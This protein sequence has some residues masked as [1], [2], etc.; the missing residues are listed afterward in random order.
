LN[1]SLPDEPPASAFFASPSGVCVYVTVA[2]RAIRVEFSEPDA[3]G[4]VA[5]SDRDA[6][7]A[8]GLASAALA[9]HREQLAPLFAL[10]AS[11]RVSSP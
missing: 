10:V 4:T 3:S 9:R 7:A 6:L 1:S 8:L 11:E 5:D 2:K